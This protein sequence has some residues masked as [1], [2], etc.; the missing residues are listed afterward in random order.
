MTITHREM[1]IAQLEAE[2]KMQAI[3]D[4][5]RKSFMKERMV[6]KAMQQPGPNPQSIPTGVESGDIR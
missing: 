1:D 3:F 4:E 2:L 5:W 6:E